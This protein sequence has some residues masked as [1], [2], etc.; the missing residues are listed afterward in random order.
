MENNKEEK[1]IKDEKKPSH[2]ETINEMNNFEH[3][4]NCDCGDDCDCF[5]NKNEKKNKNKRRDKDGDHTKI[6]FGLLIVL[7]GLFHL[8]KNLNLWD[9][10]FDWVFIWPVL[11]VVVG[12]LVM[13]SRLILK[14]LIALATIFVIVILVSTLLFYARD[15]K[16]MEKDFSYAPERSVQFFDSYKMMFNDKQKD[17]YFSGNLNR[18]EVELRISEIL[19]N[20]YGENYRDR[21]NIDVSIGNEK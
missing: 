13:G 16:K 9:I 12:L 15:N 3:D 21:M 18:A 17:V 1:K 20:I 8:G 6:F 2:D 7:F 19:N 5:D 10:N 14:W 4:S 11:I